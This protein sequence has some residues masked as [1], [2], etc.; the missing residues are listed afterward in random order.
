M[1]VESSVEIFYIL[2]KMW[3]A[4]LLTLWVNP[5]TGQTLILLILENSMHIC[6]K[7]YLTNKL[8]INVIIKKQV[9]NSVYIFRWKCLLIL[10]VI[11]LDSLI[12][13]IFGIFVLIFGLMFFVC[14][15]LQ[16]V[17]IFFINFGVLFDIL[18]QRLVLFVC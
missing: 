15:C 6:F 7:Q 5:I 8:I 4:I 11:L 16:C 1:L 3:S 13:I 18:L 10:R 14:F 9:S 2:C 12:S 17:T